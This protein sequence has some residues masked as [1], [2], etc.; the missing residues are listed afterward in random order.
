MW[1]STTLSDSTSW[2]KIDINVNHVHVTSTTK[3][4]S[5][6]VCQ[7]VFNALQM[8]KKVSIL[9]LNR[10]ALYILKHLEAKVPHFFKEDSKIKDVLSNLTIYNRE[11]VL[12]TIEKFCYLLDSSLDIFMK[13]LARA[14]VV[15][16]DGLHVLY[17]HACGL[18]NLYL[19]LQ[20]IKTKCKLITSM[21][22]NEFSNVSLRDFNEQIQSISQKVIKVKKTGQRE[23]RNISGKI[24]IYRID[25]IRVDCEHFWYMVTSRTIYFTPTQTYTKL[26]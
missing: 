2:S 23:A 24:I 13:G 10:D 9:S 5:L 19:A 8:N 26:I 21:I 20:Y 14:D 16:V 25:D 15:V 1:H 6:V 3:D 12:P 7:L 11:N 22:L 18:I 4:D 17:E